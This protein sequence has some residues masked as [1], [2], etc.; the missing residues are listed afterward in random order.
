MSSVLRGIHKRFQCIPP[1][2]NKQSVEKV[3]GNLFWQLLRKQCTL[4]KCK[5]K[6]SFCLKVILLLWCTQVK[7]KVVKSKILLRF[8]QVLRSVDSQEKAG[9]PEC[10]SNPRHRNRGFSSGGHKKNPNL[11]EQS[12]TTRWRPPSLHRQTRPKG[13]ERMKRE[14]LQ[15]V[16]PAWLKAVVQVMHYV[17]MVSGTPYGDPVHLLTRFRQGFMKLSVDNWWNFDY[18]FNVEWLLFYHGPC[19]CA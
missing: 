3:L 8:I 1:Q 14:M 11:T 17:V 2:T 15:A 16:W 5:R 18:A 13:V 10:S 6:M 12:G 19:I 4:A 7:Q 9:Q